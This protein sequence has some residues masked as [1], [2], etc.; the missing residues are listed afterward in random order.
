M[1]LNFNRPLRPAGILLTL[2]L[3]ITFLLSSLLFSQTNVGNGSIQGSVTDPSGAVVSGAK[4]TI[5]E[6]S[7]GVASIRTSDS[8]GSY[9]S[10]SLIPGVYSVRVEAPGFKTTEVPVT[11]QVDNTATANVKLEVGQ[12]SQVVEVEASSVSVNT[13]QPTVQGVITENQI[14]NLPVNG[15]NF[16][17]LAQLEP[18]V[19]I[20]DGQN[21]DPTKAGYSSIS[22]GGR[23]GRTA[24]IEVDGVDVSDETVGTTTTDIPSSAI[25]EFQI[26]QSSL[27]M[28]TELTSSGAVNVTTKSGSNAFH[29][30]AFGAF[31]DS[32]FSAALPTPV[33]FTAPFQRSQYGGDFGGPIMKNKLFFFMDGERT[34][35]HT[36]VPVPISAPFQSFSGTFSD[37]FHEGNLLG[38]LDYQLTK[39]ARAFFR[40]SDF[41]NILG[42]T[43]GYG[44]S[45]YD[46]K[47]I[48][49]N[50]VGGVDFN[51][52]SF[53]HAIRFSYLKFQNQI[54]DA[55]TGSTT[56]PFAN[57]HAE[58]FMGATGLVAGPNLLAPQSTPQSDHQLKYDGSKILGAH[59]IRYG[60]SYNHIQGGGFASFFKNGPQVSSNVTSAEIA[61]AAGGPFPGGA[62]NPYN[63]PDDFVLLSN[64]LGF[65][66][67][68]AALGFP[69]GGLGPDNRI[70]FYGGDSWKIKPNFTLSYG[71]RWMRDTGRTDS[72][73]PA[74]SGLNNLIPGEPNLGAQVNQPNNNWAPQLG[75]AW[76]P[77][78]DGKTSIRGGIGL[79]YEN[80]IWNNVLFDGPN[81]EATG[82]FLQFFP[83]CTA[84]G[85]PVPLNVAGGKQINLPGSASALGVCGTSAGF[86]L[87]GNAL[88]AITALA[89]QYIAGSPLNLQAANPSFVGSGLPNFFPSG[90][91]MFNPDYKS[92]RSVQMNIGIQRELHR[93][94]VLS[95]DFARNV[96][97][98]YLLGVD[99][100]HAG[101]INYFN[102]TGAQK[103]IAKTLSNCGVTSINAAIANCPNNPTTGTA[104]Y[105][106]PATMGDFASNGLGSSSDMGGS[107]CPAALGYDCAFGGINPNAPPIGMLSPVGRSV[108]DGLQMKWT[109]NVKSP[110]KGSTGLN[111]TASY[112]LSRFSN[113]G[114]GVRAGAPVTA[115]S[116]DQDFIVPALN[117]SNVNAYFGPST[118]DRTHQI[119]FGG[120]LDFL[121]GFQLGLIGHFDSPFSSTLTVPNT[122]TGAGEIF[123][124]DFEGSGVTQNP[125]PGTHVGSFDRG[126]NAGNINAAIAN[127][128][129][130]VAGQPTP[131]GNVLIQNGLM[132][133]TQLVSLGAV[134]PT[135]PLA[136]PNQVNLSWLRTMDM[137][138]AWTY[139]I[140]ERLTIKPS[141]G[142]YNIGNFANFDLPESMMS[143]LLTGST[144]T[145]N[146]TDYNGHFVNR[147]GVGTGVYSLGSPRQIE[148]ALKLTF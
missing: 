12:T 146:G 81:R 98:H 59:V 37:K 105:N 13:E 64:G 21:F 133:A 36:S 17:D 100:N 22:F 27:D 14:A 141:V 127:Y 122:G 125:M 136:P 71:L 2:A 56:L 119:S 94:M 45:L 139:T 79:F 19:Q 118:L 34:I 83:A 69:A 120:Y 41:Q 109:D 140:K 52:G 93:G 1:S 143:G 39:S 134:A 33:G 7:K 20:Q 77:T 25:Q 103:A 112:S 111:F 53:S 54:I 8:K 50:F 76:D 10:G 51:T 129:A 101:D 60:V 88:P 97:T 116:G 49:R 18:G 85:S 114:G 86:P 72:Q 147:V 30:D 66:T 104:G 95:V 142:F 144:G 75:F 40:F 106:A 87:I 65:S 124:T 128:N 57:I 47:D 5:T 68:K 132:T 108:Y 91:S 123:R 99:Q 73:Y 126:I 61:A 58:L 6:K 135:V 131:A 80:A 115:A 42:A 29:G 28:S 26:S 70:M 31:R 137:T 43:F 82:A 55:T 23:F 24:R 110:F 113:T 32:A 4:V 121:H 74:I 145:I 44:Y 62:G 63:Y 89:Q 3:A 96:Q 35:Q 130:T 148:F 117:N 84:A 38:R 46:N 9:T 138:L 92:P 11:V 16:L 48:T 107:S 102:L 90:N 15:R 67:T 78:K